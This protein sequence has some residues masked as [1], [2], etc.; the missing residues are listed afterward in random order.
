MTNKTIYFLWIIFFTSINI[1]SMLRRLNFSRGFVVTNKLPIQ[2]MIP[3]IINQKNMV[4]KFDG[5]SPNEILGLSKDVELSE[6]RKAYYQLAMEHHPD[7]GGNVE[8]FQKLQEAYEQMSLRVHT[9]K[10]KEE[11]KKTT[12][13]YSNIPLVDPNK[14]SITQDLRDYVWREYYTWLLGSKLEMLSDV[15]STTKNTN[16]RKHYDLLGPSFSKIESI[17]S[18][19]IIT[20]ETIFTNT[21]TSSDSSFLL[22]IMAFFGSIFGD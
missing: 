8:D 9:S 12:T 7:K 16:A 6:I 13:N 4:S 10:H 19:S 21:E 22:E 1:Q 17:D 3:I 20:S 15:I 14:V 2:A 11:H 18:A 5:K